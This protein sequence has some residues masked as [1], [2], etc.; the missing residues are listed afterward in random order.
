[1]AHNENLMDTLFF[2]TVYFWEFADAHKTIPN[3]V[4][5]S[6]A[7]KYSTFCILGYI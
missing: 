4:Q 5:D 7:R 2:S 3:G 1:M 6:T